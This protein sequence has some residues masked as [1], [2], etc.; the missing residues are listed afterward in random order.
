M[1]LQLAPTENQARGKVLVLGDRIIAEKIE[2]DLSLEGFVIFSF[3]QIENVFPEIQDPFL[4]EKLRVLLKELKEKIDFIHPGVSLWAENAELIAMCHEYGISIMAPSPRCIH[5]FANKLNFLSHAHSLRIP[6]LVSSFD[7]LSTVGEIKHFL[8]KNKSKKGLFPLVLKSIHSSGLQIG[9]FVVL[10][11]KSLEQEVP[12]WIENIRALTGEDLFL[13]EYYLEGAKHITVPF[14]QLD[15]GPLHIFPMIDTTLQWRNHKILEF[16]PVESLTEAAE[17]KIKKYV[18]EFLE[19]ILYTGVGALEFMVE[20]DRVFIVGGIP[21]L[22]SSFYLWEKITGT[23]AVTWQSAALG[24]C[25]PPVIKEVKGSFVSLRVYAENSYYQIPCPGVVVETFHKKN[26]MSENCEAELVYSVSPESEILSHSEGLVATLISHSKSF[27]ESLKYLKIVLGDLWF[28]GSL[29]TNEKFLKQLMSHPWV[30]KGI[31]HASFIEEEFIPD[32]FI[33]EEIKSIFAGLVYHMLPN[34]N[35]W[36]RVNERPVIPHKDISFITVSEKKEFN[37]ISYWSG[38]LLWKK[39]K[40]RFCVYPLFN[41]RY[42]VRVGSLFQIVRTGE[43]LTRVITKIPVYSLVYGTVHSVLFR[44]GT[45]V[46]KGEVLFLVESLNSVV[47]HSL[48]EEVT[49]VESLVQAQDTVYIG[50]VLGYVERIKK[51]VK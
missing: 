5:L 47:P 27:E 36:Y 29:Q 23:K 38:W 13:V 41:F 9:I 43:V 15:K 46:P 2:N 45:Q 21:R 17:N 10:D 50:Q 51:G 35:Q 18:K 20:G 33:D 49:F 34:E 19:S 28:A 22:N 24:W 8:E 1:S 44:K 7:P 39:K 32:L 4:L 11:E 37:G 26:W 16:A 30:Q 25:S 42:Q 12:L 3:S 31:V 14:A 40:L 48:P 6:H